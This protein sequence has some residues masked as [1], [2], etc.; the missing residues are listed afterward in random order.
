M[1]YT[2]FLQKA[3]DLTIEETDNQTFYLEPLWRSILNDNNMSLKMISDVKCSWIDIED[4]LKLEVQKRNT[5]FSKTPIVIDWLYK[6]ITSEIEPAMVEQ[7]TE[8]VKK[9]IEQR[10]MEKDLS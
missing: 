2:E 7:Q 1:L 6:V 5:V 4:V 10:N 9:M 8:I 3:V